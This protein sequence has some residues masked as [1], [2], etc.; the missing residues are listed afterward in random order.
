MAKVVEDKHSIVA[1]GNFFWLRPLVIGLI[2]G[3]A[4]WIFWSLLLNNVL[5]VS[6]NAGSVAVIGVTVLGAYLL[7]Q[8]SEPRPLVIAIA[9]SVILWS[10]GGYLDGL[11]YIES[12]LWS[13]A[14]FGAS[15]TLFGLVVR[16]RETWFV[17]VVASLV[18][19]AIVAALNLL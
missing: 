8:W 13:L 10:L 3:A 9:S 15:Y 12:L 19:I 11:S 5:D 2:V 7:I 17:L 6:Q 1:P 18:V 14:F 16:I 4:W